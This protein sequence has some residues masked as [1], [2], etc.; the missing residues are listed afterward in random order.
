MKPYSLLFLGIALLAA[1]ASGQVFTH[2]LDGVLVDCGTEKVVIVED[3]ESKDGHFAAA[4]T[5]HPNGKK[6]PVNWSAYTRKDPAAF[7]VK[8]P[9]GDAPGQGSYSLVNGVVNLPG[10]TFVPLP[11]QDPYYPGKEHGSLRV[12]WS[13]DR[14]GVRYGV[15]GNTVGSNH[16]ENTVE[17]FL[18]ALGG[19]GGPRVADL[20]ADADK[21]VRGYLHKRDPK[22]APRYE[23]SYDFT[24][25]AEG[26]KKGRPQ[27]F[28]GDTLT[29]HFNAEIPLEDSEDP[30]CVSFS[31]PKGNV[32]GIVS[33]KAK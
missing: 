33:D 4:W 5:L 6:A 27:V 22:D 2:P 26:S 32:T 9:V 8:F 21:A 30:G 25:F 31:L 16:S 1:R 17:L 28:K 24:E 19:P 14:Q 29:A 23:W 18:V 7:L 3:T 11:S 15:V 12:A 13:D 20:K 10:K